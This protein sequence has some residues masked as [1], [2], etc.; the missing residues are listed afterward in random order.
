MDTLYLIH[1]E[2]KYKHA[3]HYLGLSNDL[4]RRMDEHRS[5]QGSA[6]MKAVT[7]AEIPWDVVRTWK[8]ADRM[9]E[10]RLKNQK[11]AWRLCPICNPKHYQNRE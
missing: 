11:N 10:R 8:H 5:G 1:F 9:L 7:Q 4:S 3:Q 6:L 2:A